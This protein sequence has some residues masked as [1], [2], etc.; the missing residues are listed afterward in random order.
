MITTWRS[1]IARIAEAI[2]CG[3][4][5]STGSG[6]AVMTSQ[7]PH[8]RVHFEPR[9]RNVASRASQHSA[10]FGHIASSQT[11]CSERSRM[12]PFSSL[13]FGVSPSINALSTFVRVFSLILLGLGALF[14][15]RSAKRG[16]TAIDV[17]A[18]G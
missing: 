10:M 14:S 9:S 6:L 16:V 3:S 13:K 7:N 17:N 2:R 12:M 8:L 11:V 5:S 18:L 15:A 4:S 1:P